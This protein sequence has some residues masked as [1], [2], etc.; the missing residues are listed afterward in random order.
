MK[1]KMDEVASII[2]ALGKQKKG[3]SIKGSAKNITLLVLVL[4]FAFGIYGSF[5]NSLINMAEYVTFLESFT[6]FFAPLI[7]SIGAGSATK[8]I[9]KKKEDE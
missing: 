9:M 3:N 7:V 4:A 2:E 1:E 8:N 5:S 6:W